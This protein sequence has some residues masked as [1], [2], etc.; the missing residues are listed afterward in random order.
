MNEPLKGQLW[1]DDDVRTF[2]D[3]K[4][5]SE[6]TMSSPRTAC[7]RFIRGKI[8]LEEFIKPSD[9]SI[10]ATRLARAI[11]VPTHLCRRSVSSYL[12]AYEPAV[13]IS[14]VAYDAWPKI[15]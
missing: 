7:G 6:E 15:S 14:G 1:H 3:E 2:W 12:P 8:L 9:L 5:S 11:G 10:N 4:T 13:S